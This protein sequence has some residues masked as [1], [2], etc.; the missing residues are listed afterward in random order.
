MHDAI[1]EYIKV[2]NTEVS[3]KELLSYY[4]LL[5]KNNS[6]KNKKDEDPLRKPKNK[7]EKQFEVCLLLRP[8]V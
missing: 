1:L 5:L 3:R 4:N 2:G 6:W 7:I 8:I